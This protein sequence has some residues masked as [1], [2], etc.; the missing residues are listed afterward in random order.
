MLES[1]PGSLV[2]GIRQFYLSSPSPEGVETED[3]MGQDQGQGEKTWGG[4]KEQQGPGFTQ[5]SPLTTTTGDEDL[6]CPSWRG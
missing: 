4:T 2:D 1:P 5:P 6:G 3:V